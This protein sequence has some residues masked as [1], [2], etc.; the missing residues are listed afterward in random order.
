M[1]ST[2][3]LSKKNSNC[4]LCKSK[5]LFKFLDLGHHPPSDQFL[6]VDE[7]VEPVIYYPLEVYICEDCGFVQLGYTV[8][9]EVLYQRNYPYESSTTK[10]GT[11]HYH[12]F[13]KS[14]VKEFNFASNDLAVDIG[15]NV[16]VLLHG[17][18]SMG[19]RVR[20]VD[21]AKNICMIAEKNGIPT[22]PDFFCRSAAERILSENGNA[23]V[24][25]G[26]NVFAHIE[27]L[28]ALLEAVMIL[29]HPKKGIFIIE[30]P[31][32]LHMITNL[33]YDTIY[34]EHLSYLSIEPLIPFFKKHNMEIIKI[35][36]KDIHGGSIRIFCAKCG[37]YR[38][39]E[40]VEMII[41]S[42][43]SAGLKTKKTMINFA[44]K[45]EKNKEELNTLLYNLKK[46]GKKIV[47]VSAPAKGM[48]LLN[49]CKID[50]QL[51][52]FITEKSKL[53]IGLYTPGSHIEVFPDAKLLEDN[54]DY[55]LLLAWN[56]SKEII[57]NNA[58]YQKR[59]GK[60]IIPIP[61]PVII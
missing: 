12:D 49:Y 23:S 42:E 22:I 31:H 35:E 61:S 7:I 17:F 13:S 41:A 45:V 30:A 32:L 47:G 15:S 36:Q 50:K 34:H 27:D 56:F 29:L 58:E 21:P 33:E 40:S 39:H 1:V 8:S 11:T 2:T 43:K 54:P 9:P 3:S 14:V 20:G 24:I 6:N 37:N 55:A 16:G 60:F 52:D 38:I 46:S 57:R 28:D 10:T 51:L 25:T 48:T 5:K 59:G 4:R 19:L 44:R 26:T 18:K 53:K